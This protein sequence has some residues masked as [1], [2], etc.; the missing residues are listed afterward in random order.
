M[1]MIT[2][3]ETL[4]Y[5]NFYSI[6]LILIIFLFSNIFLKRPLI[7]D[8]KGDYSGC[9]GHL[10]CGKGTTWEGGQRVP[11]MISWPSKIEPG[12]THALASTLDIMPTI[13]S[14][15]GE[16]IP[17]NDVSYD[18]SDLLFNNGEVKSNFLK[19]LL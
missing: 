14:I 2:N 10:R 17:E 11:G 5:H 7:H 12:V 8:D 13:M 1:G 6:Q 18:L 19:C 16:E 3:Q 4:F 15:V 9:A